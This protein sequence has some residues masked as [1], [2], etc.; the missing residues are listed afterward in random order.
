[1]ETTATAPVARSAA[2]DSLVPEAA[3][4]EAVGLAAAIRDGASGALHAHDLGLTAALL[5]R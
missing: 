2:Q 5:A 4:A 3:V 1:M